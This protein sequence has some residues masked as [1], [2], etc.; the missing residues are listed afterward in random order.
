MSSLVCIAREQYE[1]QQVK[2]SEFLSRTVRVA[3][4]TYAHCFDDPQ[5]RKTTDP[6]SRV[7]ENLAE[8][9]QSPNGT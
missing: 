7:A 9:H 3:Y 4:C 8:S 1:K 6:R 2:P 5:T